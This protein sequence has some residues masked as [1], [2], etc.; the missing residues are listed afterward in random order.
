MGLK[1]SVMLSDETVSYISARHKDAEG[2]LRW[3]AAVNGAVDTLRSI[4]RAN[5]PTLTE[6]AW[7]L[8][9]NAH[10]GH[11]F[12]W[13]PGAPMRLASD[14]MDDLGVISIESLSQE[15]ADAVR[16]IHGLS[17]IEQ[18]TAFE[19][20]RIFWATTNKSG[21]LMEMVENCRRSL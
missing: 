13:R 8:L 9:L 10:A 2:E 16:E 11:F 1:K 3:S 17:Q 5:S 15:D 20:I 19:V 4:Y 12:D 7:R 14:V 18:M 21:D 6:R